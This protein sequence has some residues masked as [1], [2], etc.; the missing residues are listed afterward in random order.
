MATATELY[1]LSDDVVADEYAAAVFEDLKKLL[2]GKQQGH[3]QRL[4]YLPRPVMD[5]LGKSLAN[6]SELVTQK[7]VTKVLTDKAANKLEDWE[8]TG[9]GAVALREE[10]TYKKIRVFCALFPAGIRLAEEDSLNIATF[11]TDDAES[12]NITKCLERHLLGKVN[13]LPP[14]ERNLMLAVLNAEAVRPKPVH[15]KLRYVLAVLG[16]RQQSAQPINAEVVGAYL[17]ELGLIPDFDLKTGSL[18][19]Q[20]SRNQECVKVLSNGD[21][22]LGQNLEDLAEKQ[23]LQG[24]E[25]RKNLAIYLA[26]RNM[27]K[28]ENWLPD[29]CHDEGWREKLSFDSWKFAKPITG[30]H[31]ELKPLQDPKKPNKVAKGLELRQGVL[32]NDGKTPIEIKWDLTPKDSKDVSG[33]RIYLVRTTEE[34]TE[35]DV[36]AP[37]TAAAKRKSFK[38]PVADNNLEP[39]EKCVA[40]IRV[41]V[42]G[43]NGTPI[44][45]AQDESEE[46]WI[47]NGQVVTP[48][49]PEKGRRLRHIDEL[50]FRETYKTGKEFEVRHRGWDPGH[51]N[52]FTVRLSNNTRGDLVLNPLLK[53]VERK[54]LEDPATLGIYEANVVDRRRAELSDFKVVQVVQP[55]SQAAT[56]FYQARSKFFASVRDAEDGQGVI[57]AVDLHEHATEVAE[58]VQAYLDLLD[59]LK[60]NVGT[61]AGPGKINNVLADYAQIMRIDSVLL[62]VGGSDGSMDVLLLAPT[63]PLRVMWLYQYQS[64]VR[65][66]IQ[67]MAGKDPSAIK[68]LISEDSID[69]IVDLNIPNAIAWSQDR[70]FI[71]TDNLDLFWSVLPSASVDDLRTAVNAALQAIGAGRKEVVISTVTPGQLADKMKRYLC[72]HP[73][74]RT[75]KI[76]V[77]NPGD[78]SVLLEAM[79]RLIE[80]ELY[81]DINFDLKFFTPPGTKHHLVASAFDDLME[82]RDDRDYS[83]G[84]DISEQEEYLLQPNAN[85]LFPKLIYAK[86]S[87]DDLL[88]NDNGRFESHLTLVIDYFGTTVATRTHN[89]P[90]D[91]SALHNLIAEYVTDYTPGKTTATWSR[92]VAP[93]QCPPLASDGNTERLFQCQDHLS[94]LASSF[95]DWGKS[96]DKYITIQLEL[97]DENGKN[98]LKM[99]RK[100]HLTS[101]WVFTI[102]RNFGIEYYDDPTAGPAGESG[103]YLI[104]YT[105]EFLDAISHRLIISTYHQHEIES[106]L[107]RGFAKLLDTETQEGPAIDSYQIGRI[108][109]VLKSV[110]GKLALKLINNPSQAQEVI[111][112]ALTRMILERDSR[113]AGAVLIPVDSHIQLFH[114]TPKELENSELTLKRTDLILARLDGM[115]LNLDLIEVK[116]YKYASP[117][118]LLELQAAIRD[119]NKNTEAHF[120]ANFLSGPALRRL[121]AEIKNKELATI[122]AFYF[123]RANRY[124]LFAPADSGAAP[125]DVAAKFRE[126]LEAVEAGVC[127]VSFHHF[128]YIFNSNSLNEEE[129]ITFQNNQVTVVGRPG[130]AKLLDLMLDGNGDEPGPEEPPPSPG[131]PPE[132]PPAPST[133]KAG[134]GAPPQTPPP[135]PAPAA[136]EA[137][138]ALYASGAP[139]APVPHPPEDQ[140]NIFL[141]TNA[142][143]GKPAYWNPYTTKPRKLSNQH[144]LV[145]GKSGAGKSE[146]TKALVWEL[147]SRNVPSIIFDY[148]GE[149]ATGE[150][151][152]AV[153]P[154]VFDVMKGLPINPF[155]LPIDPLTGRKR[156][157]IEMVFRLADTLNSVFAGSGDI[158]MGTLREA[159]DLC[160]QQHGFDRDNPESWNNEPPTLEML[161]AVLAQM[162]TDRGAQVKNLQVRLQ[163]LF[164]SGIFR[165]KKAEFDFDQLFKKTTVLLLTAGIKDLMLAASRFILEKVY[166]SMLMAGVS[167]TLRVMAVI[168]E[169]HKLC[170]DETVTSLIKEARKYGMGIILSSQETR[171]FHPSVFANTGTLVGLAL[172]EEDANVMSKYMGL[173]DK[174]E[175]TQAKELLLYQANGQALIRSQHFLPYAQVKILSFEDRLARLA[176]NTEGD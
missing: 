88:Q 53:A 103:G 115:T 18:G 90:P 42:L 124:R 141:G 121:D 65:A 174:T 1:H 17:Y 159:I 151:F 128:G 99:L 27:L 24:A 28:P 16:E 116:N 81:H 48:P 10:A 86:H 58:Y 131:L 3:C 170:G 66:W 68:R 61:A 39:D 40:R 98:H 154:Q 139:A 34:G 2:L 6:D 150:F 156:P 152:E 106:I 72:H 23:G 108:L 162:A 30:V 70:V 46:F 67:Q 113:L 78:A 50:R 137:V 22:T 169:A 175:R 109:Q 41:Q 57:E 35:I 147:A 100:A 15:Q 101:D 136:S 111:G 32:T 118:K 167:K 166:S 47:E 37:Q 20:V 69:K 11:K 63:H 157:Y 91:S 135:P 153:K 5:R 43:K 160:F 171:D 172:E 127:Q 75:L 145:V 89:G 56:A 148:Q 173:T 146:T 60:Q 62:T 45:N 97:T 14:D 132:V 110:S 92:L 161:E 71:N 94:R 21:K 55:V 13:L 52:V 107:K 165:K 49:P 168:D 82:F 144:I 155:E 133:P 130:I 64:Y 8:T 93:N 176:S 149:Y 143:T 105:P 142:V 19:A 26:E 31:I 25:I 129:K 123:D 134:G 96:L 74:V 73:Y 33:F 119:K 79:E 114:Q 59:S 77:I 51:E 85:P 29:I 54:I 76:N 36:I 84:G 164:K 125:E 163:P 9:S 4:D 7:I 122:L 12:F 138:S 140:L 104:D 87:I 83:A 158:Q 44:P 102:D 80:D 120:N 112:L 38:V 126:A 95:Y 117:Q